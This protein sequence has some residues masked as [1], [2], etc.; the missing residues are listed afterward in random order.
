MA[1][2]L[3]DERR[4]STVLTL[5]ANHLLTFPEGSEQI[6]FVASR[7]YWVYRLYNG[8]FIREH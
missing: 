7:L 5:I 8:L 1:T 6:H 4:R 3:L 2:L